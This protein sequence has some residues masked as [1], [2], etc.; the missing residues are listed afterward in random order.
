MLTGSCHCGAVQIEVLRKPR[1]LTRCTCSICRRYAALWAY[2]TAKTARIRHAAGAV[3]AY[4]WNERIL[5]F[6]HCR[7]CGCVTHYEAADKRD[8]KRIAINARMLPAADLAGIRIR[9]F[10]GALTWKYLDD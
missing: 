5:S 10:D 6:V 2:C 7:T 1:S 4:R 8:H 9:T 3:Q